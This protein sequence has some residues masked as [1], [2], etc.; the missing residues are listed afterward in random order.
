MIEESDLPDSLLEKTQ[1]LEGLVTA[2]ATGDVGAS[3]RHY[4][5]LRRE[6]MLNPEI[7][8]LLPDFIRT[9]RSLDV[10]WPY[11]QKQEKTWAGRRQLIGQAFTPVI[12]FLQ[13]KHVA[14]GDLAT[15]DALRSFDVEGVH[16]IWAKALARR[17]TD[18][19][20]A[21]TTARTLVEAVCKRILDEQSVAYGEAE[22]LPKLYALTAKSLN[23]APDQHTAE[24]IR[25]ILGSAMNLINGI[26][27]LRNRLGD[28]HARGGRQVKPSTRHANLAV[29]CAGA[30][31][32]FLVETFA[33]RKRTQA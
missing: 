14:P 7:K 8:P 9:C 29:N 17:F 10:F 20:G 6:L 5:Y 22:D 15:S 30:L 12:E 3:N 18:P 25:A 26:G 11:I 24:P 32:T 27:T 4:E 31:A 19:E 23:L 33:E 28:S 2:K 1:M 16:E 21:I 13:N